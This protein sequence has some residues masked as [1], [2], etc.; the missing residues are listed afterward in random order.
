MAAEKIT[1]WIAV[2]A[3]ISPAWIPLLETVSQYAAL[4]LPILGVIWLANQIIFKVR[5][6][7]GKQSR[8]I[9]T[10]LDGWPVPP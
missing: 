1:D 5:E 6:G 9:C 10:K 4:S 2:G 7:R 3:V 8:P